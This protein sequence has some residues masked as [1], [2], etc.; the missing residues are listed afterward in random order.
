M[1]RIVCVVISLL[2]HSSFVSASS[3]KNLLKV[4]DEVFGALNSK[5]LSEQRLAKGEWNRNKNAIAIVGNVKGVV[6]Q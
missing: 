2:I 4:V 3:N 6:L 1:I 5:K